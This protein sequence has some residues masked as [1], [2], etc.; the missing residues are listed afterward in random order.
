[1]QRI[2]WPLCTR[3]SLPLCETRNQCVQ[4]GF[5]R[6]GVSTCQEKISSVAAALAKWAAE[7]AVGDAISS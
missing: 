2:Q 7:R 1:M 4:G 3:T 5:S 6:P